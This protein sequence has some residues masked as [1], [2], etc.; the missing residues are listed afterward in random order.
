MA[1]EEIQSPDAVEVSEVEASDASEIETSD[2]EVSEGEDS[3]VEAAPVAENADEAPEVADAFDFG[4]VFSDDFEEGSVPEEHRAA[5]ASV[6]EHVQQIRDQ[7]RKTLE[8]AQSQAKY[9][10]ELYM[11]LLRDENPQR[12]QEFEK[13]IQ[14]LQQEIKNRQ[15]VIDELALDRDNIRQEFENHAT[16]S[17]EQYL[18]YVERKWMD[19]LTSDRDNNN[20]VVLKSAE[21]MVVELGF[22]PDEALE[23]GFRH[24]LEAMAEAADFVD[25]GMKPEDAYN[26]A[27]RIYS[28]F[29][30][31]PAQPA[32][33]AATHSPSAELADDPVQR[34]APESVPAGKPKLHNFTSTGLDSFLKE[35]AQG[36]FTD[37]R[38]RRRR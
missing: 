37:E 5:V 18:A 26:L 8:E 16:S 12:F 29:V 17:N 30:E 25:K 11:Q 34:R 27:K 4:S 38:F 32:T 24:G 14:E 35:T 31:E 36:L 10:Q 21:E 19:D 20:G 15:K 3:E 22:D 1:A 13:Q 23:L 2:V 33:P 6:R 9:N 7:H 28:S